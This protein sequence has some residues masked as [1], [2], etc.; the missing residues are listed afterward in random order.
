MRVRAVRASLVLLDERRQLVER[1]V[2]RRF[3]SKLLVQRQ[4]TSMLLNLLNHLVDLQ[5]NKRLPNNQ[6]PTQSVVRIATTETHLR[7]GQI[8]NVSLFVLK[9]C[10]H[11]VVHKLPRIIDPSIRTQ[12]RSRA[13]GVCDRVMCQEINEVKRRQRTSSSRARDALPRGIRDPK[14]RRSIAGIFDL[15]SL[16]NSS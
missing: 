9:R 6:W 4:V 1:R 2:E 12:T 7:G 3:D 5:I 15:S 8:R 10:V 16:S 13:R 14:S 11:E